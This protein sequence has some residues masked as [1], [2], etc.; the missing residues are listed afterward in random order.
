MIRTKQNSENIA[1]VPYKG[2]RAVSQDLE[3]QFTHYSTQI[4]GI[5]C[6]NQVSIRSGK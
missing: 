2:R 1:L 3:S 4:P 6:I 5:Q